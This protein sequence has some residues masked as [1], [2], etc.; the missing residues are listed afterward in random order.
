MLLAVGGFRP[1]LAGTKQ[2]ASAA[3]E[4]SVGFDK[5]KPRSGLMLLPLRGFGDSNKDASRV[6]A[7]C[8]DKAGRVADT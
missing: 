2:A 6:R 7:A 5:T 3:T 8:F 4:R 1:R